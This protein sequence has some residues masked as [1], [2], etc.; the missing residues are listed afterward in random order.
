MIYT[1]EKL[2]QALLTLNDKGTKGQTS[3][4]QRIIQYIVAPKLL[5]FKEKTMLLTKGKTKIT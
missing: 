5:N 1:T 4:L 2:E 3:M